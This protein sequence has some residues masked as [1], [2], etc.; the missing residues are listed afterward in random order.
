LAESA[1]T[2]LN[3]NVRTAYRCSSDLADRGA[4]RFTRQARARPGAIATSD[5]SGGVLD[6]FGGA[7]RDTPWQFTFYYSLGALSLIE[8]HFA[9]P[10]SFASISRIIKH[11]RFAGQKPLYQAHQL[12]PSLVRQWG[13]EIDPDTHVKVRCLGAR[14]HFGDEAS[15]RSYYGTGAPWAHAGQSAAVEPAGRRFALNRRPETISE[16]PR[17]GAII[18]QVAWPPVHHGLTVV[19]KWLALEIPLVSDRRFLLN[20]SA[21]LFD[22]SGYGLGEYETLGARSVHA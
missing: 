12:D 10:L 20:T 22:C 9:K 8:R 6:S 19:S 4:R 17:A 16:D 11:L 13:P 18:L 3:L 5:A 1:A 15:N 2:S 14:T 21:K 7:R